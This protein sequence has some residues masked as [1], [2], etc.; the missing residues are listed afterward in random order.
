MAKISNIESGH[1]DTVFKR[2]EV[3]KQEKVKII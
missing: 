1:F 2:K 3:R